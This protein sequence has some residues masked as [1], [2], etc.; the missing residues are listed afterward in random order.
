MHLEGHP[1]IPGSLDRDR[2]SKRTYITE[3]KLGMAAAC[4]I[5]Q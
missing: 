1:C 4:V 5:Q 3:I 2:V